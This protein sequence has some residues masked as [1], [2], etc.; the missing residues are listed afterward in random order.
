M[1]YATRAKLVTAARDLAIEGC[2]NDPT[3][4][5]IVI[6]CYETVGDELTDLAQID[7]GLR[8]HICRIYDKWA[9]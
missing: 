9:H 3:D 4:D 6:Y 8:D 7:Q 2:L 5:D 1:P